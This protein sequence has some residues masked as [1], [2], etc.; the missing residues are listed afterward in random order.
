VNEDEHLRYELVQGPLALLAERAAASP[1]LPHV[2][3]IDEI[4]RA[5]LPRVFGE[6][7][8]LLEYRDEAVKTLYRPEEAFELPKNLYFIG[9]MNTAD[10]SIALVDA[11]L[12][13]RFH[14]IPFF[15]N[16]SPIAGLLA[17]WL[18]R[19]DPSHAYVADLVD[20]V[21][22]ELR[23]RLGGP[24]LQ[25]GPSHFMVNDLDMAK[26]ER[27]WNY[28]IFPFIEEQLFGEWSEIEE[29]RFKA[30]WSRFEAL[31]T[32]EMSEAGDASEI[33]PEPDGSP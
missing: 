29:Y 16:E 5:N 2:L 19:H 33:A 6:L 12:R 4:N 22:Q 14:F 25:I 17:R 28:S 9:T 8:F 1:G 13:R 30:V 11:A 24:H 26:L 27:V 7:L 20:M 10:R 23:E 3:I 21:N 31:A 18:E 32:P 15:P